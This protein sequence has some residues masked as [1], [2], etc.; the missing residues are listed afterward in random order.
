MYH[1]VCIDDDKIT[2]KWY[3]NV[4]LPQLNNVT[5]EIFGED[6]SSIPIFLTTAMNASLVLIDYNLDYTNASFCGTQL[7]QLLRCNGFLGRIVIYTASKEPIHFFT[8]VDLVL[9]KGETLT[10]ITRK[11]MLELNKV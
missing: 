9:Y 7:A 3:D 10:K 8:V 11:L 6:A 1:I 2:R 4:L 5:W